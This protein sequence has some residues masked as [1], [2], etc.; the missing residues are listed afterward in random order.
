MRNP[1]ANQNVIEPAKLAPVLMSTHPHT[2]TRTANEASMHRH[3][4]TE[5]NQATFFSLFILKAVDR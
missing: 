5:A 4:D 2:T 3:D 1:N